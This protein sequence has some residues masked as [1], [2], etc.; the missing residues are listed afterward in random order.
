MEVI[1]LCRLRSARSQVNHILAS[2]LLSDSF[3]SSAS[4]LPSRSN[5]QPLTRSLKTL[6]EQTNRCSTTLYICRPL[7]VRHHRSS[8]CNHH[9][10]SHSSCRRPVFTRIMANLIPWFNLQYTPDRVPTREPGYTYVQRGRLVRRPPSRGEPPTRFPAMS[11]PTP[12]NYPLHAPPAYHEPSPFPISRQRDQVRVHAS[13]I[14]R[15]ERELRQVRGEEEPRRRR[16]HSPAPSSSSSSTSSSSSSATSTSS[17]SSDESH[18]VHF[19]PSSGRPTRGQRDAHPRHPSP[20]ACYDLY[21]DGEYGAYN[22]PFAHDYNHGQGMNERYGYGMPFRGQAARGV[23]H[24]Q[25]H[26]RRG[27]CFGGPGRWQDTPQF[28]P[29]QGQGFVRE[30]RWGRRR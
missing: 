5:L 9:S 28:D 23:P 29:C 30:P 18:H 3:R 21:L 2:P 22:E 15:L 20:H 27:G 1:Q 24:V 14:R 17:S 12:Y 7:H 13:N 4:A 19:T 25:T 16:C 26:A 11:M 6:M 10:S 8:P